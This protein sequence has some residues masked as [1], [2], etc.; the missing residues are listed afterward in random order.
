MREW[1]MGG[2]KGTCVIWIKVF[3][4]WHLVTGVVVLKVE[5][6]LGEGGEWR[7]Q[8]NRWRPECSWDYS[9]IDTDNLLDC[10]LDINQGRSISR[11]PNSVLKKG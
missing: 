11:K 3:L 4:F 7:L 1:I 8:S 5:G 10:R 9:E 6:I 2:T